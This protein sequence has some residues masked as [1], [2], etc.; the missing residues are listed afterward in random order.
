MMTRRRL[1][2]ALIILLGGG[3]WDGVVLSNIMGGIGDSITAANGAGVG[4]KTYTN[5]VG[6]FIGY[7]M[8]LPK[9][10]DTE[11]NGR[12]RPGPISGVT[13][14]AIHDLL[15]TRLPILLSSTPKPG[16]CVVLG[17]TND[18]GTMTSQALIDS[19]LADL[20][21]IY[22]S[23]WN[24]SIMPIACG[25]PTCDLYAGLYRTRVI[26]FNPQVEALATSMGIPYVNFFDVTDDGSAGW[27]ADY[28]TGDGIHPSSLGAAAMGLLLRDTLD[29]Y[30]LAYTPPLVTEAT[31]GDAT[32]L[33]GNGCF[34][35][36][37]NADGVP[38]NWAIANGASEITCSL[39]DGG[40]EV[41]GNWW[42]INKTAATAESRVRANITG[43]TAGTRL[44]FG[45]RMKVASADQATGMN[46]EGYNP[47]NATQKV[48]TAVLADL[49]AA[50]SP[51]TFYYENTVPSGATAL[52]FD[53]QIYSGL[54]DVYIGQFTARTL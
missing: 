29:S 6:G 14:N 41:E 46:F 1:S 43:L 4:I 32:F 20:S 11:G 45:F 38:D 26:A 16:F 33:L 27:I 40:S 44:G 54:V 13:G 21:T 9:T 10:G 22:N 25:L 18:L 31:Q 39:V 28:D 35:A 7:S 42:R 30:L 17:G 15:I 51:Y 49:R 2:S 52:R 53:L 12:L 5:P 24:S 19:K 8:I 36:D 48:Y 37:T 47:S 23:L 34:T 50:V 3:R